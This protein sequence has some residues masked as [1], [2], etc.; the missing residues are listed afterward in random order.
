MVE[1][2]FIS[3]MNREQ[4]ARGN[5]LQPKPGDLILR[6]ELLQSQAGTENL[7]YEL[8]CVGAGVG[9]HFVSSFFVSGC[10]SPA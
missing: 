4:V 10:H 7:E 1:E 5:E 6:K 8:A 9:V 3:S 2:R